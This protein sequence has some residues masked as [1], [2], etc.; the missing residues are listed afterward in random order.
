VGYW[1]RAGSLPQVGWRY[2]RYL[3]SPLIPDVPEPPEH[4]E[5]PR[6]TDK[7]KLDSGFHYRVK[8]SVE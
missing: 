5:P 7:T 2:P 4:L 6:I 3:E 1:G 8:A